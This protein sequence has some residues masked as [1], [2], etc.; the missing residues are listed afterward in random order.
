MS[1]AKANE[2]GRHLRQLFGPGSGVGLT[3]SHLL[4]RFASAAR[5]GQHAAD[6]AEAAFETILARHGPTVLSVCRQLLRDGHAAEDAFQATFLVLARRATSLHMRDRSSLGPWL[7]GVA[8][9]TAL[10][11]RKSASRRLAREH[12]TARP[13]AQAGPAVA[14]VEQADVGAALHAEVTRLPAKY[15]VP[16]V[17]CYFEGRTHDETAAALSWPVG[18]VRSR[19]S[20]A[21]DLLR[22]R[23]TRRGLAPASLAGTAL[24]A[25]SAQAEVPAPLFH[26]TLA[27]AMRTAPASAPRALARLVLNTLFAARLRTAAAAL[28]LIAITAGLAFALRGAPAAPP[29]RSPTPDPAVNPIVASAPSLVDLPGAELPTHARARLGPSGFHHGDLANQVLYSHDGKTLITLGWK[30]VVCVWDTTTGRLRHQLPL[31]GDL[32]DRIAISPDGTTLATTE[33]DPDRRLRLWDVATG[34]ERR[35]WHLSKDHGCTAPS[36][37][38]DGRTLI[39]LGQPYEAPGRQFKRYF[40]LWDLTAPSERL[41]RVLGNGGLTQDFQISPDGKTL[42]AITSKDVKAQEAAGNNPFGLFGPPAEEN[43]VRILDLA[44][45]RDLAV[46]CV[47]GVFFQSIAFSPDGQ[48]LATALD[49]GTVRVFKATT[50]QERLP[51]VGRAPDAGP[52]SERRGARV[53][54]GLEVIDSLAFAPDGSILAGGSSRGLSTPSPGALYLWDFASGRELRRIGGFRVGPTSLSY[55]PDGKT[56]AT[57]GSWEAMPRFWDV[58]TG[59]EAFAQPAHVMGI[60]TLAVSP[61]DG[62]IFTGSYDGTVRHWDPNTGRELGEIARFNSVLTLA[63]APDGKTLI[64]GGQFG[65]PALWSVPERREIRRFGDQREGTLRQ[66]AYS[67]DGK[68]VAF[69]R[70][71]SDAA[72]GRL[73]KVLHAPD[74]RDGYAPPSNMFYTSDGKRLI[75][76]ERGVIRTWDLATGTEARPAIRSETI[77]GDHAAVSA[78]GRFVA[79]GGVPQM[80]GVA[81]PRD[82]W[83]RVWDLAK[84]SERARVPTQKDSVSGVAL[85]PDGRL[86]ASFRPNQPGDRIVFEPQPQDPTIRIWE[87]ATGRELRLLEGHRGPVNAVLFTPDG[88][89]LVS[90]GEDA[91]ALVW[92]I[93]DL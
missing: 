49:D 62:T 34:R 29:S 53:D 33:P 36:F 11:A 1:S 40:E 79:T 37:S 6:D 45:S 69:D 80:A 42:A 14:R 86:L 39:T 56:I 21:R 7:H 90:A 92:D 5:H 24:S 38:P 13:E 3:D 58:A 87:V 68:T 78:D 46:L 77:L 91:T 88:R 4:D 67:P 12:R 81:P 93:S 43:E 60:S 51:R 31:S 73:L 15:R 52:P 63:V 65:D 32:F 50:G 23:L 26:A 44:T 85:S 2:V 48:Y 20:R 41:R 70:K 82:P 10:K 8:Y 27:A 47:E 75:T 17:L 59:R 25:R 28:G 76:A 71:I 57:A 72:S 61:A 74:E 83:I 19:L 30:R 84:G 16:V 35:R 64:V 55:A 54:A 22:T 9:R 66:C 89:S 18:T